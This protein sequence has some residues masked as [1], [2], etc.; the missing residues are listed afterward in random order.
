M[1]KFNHLLSIS[2]SFIVHLNFFYTEVL[3]D[4]CNININ[5]FGFYITSFYMRYLS[6]SEIFLSYFQWNHSDMRHII[7]PIHFWK[8][9]SHDRCTVTD[10]TLL[11]IVF[12]CWVSNIFVEQNFFIIV[13]NTTLKA[14]NC[15]L[16]IL[17]MIR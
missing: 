12:I 2:L 13:F 9:S 1:V 17:S 15:L 14:R 6:Y 16:L 7:S 8:T 11:I 10:G 4:V 3:S 5:R